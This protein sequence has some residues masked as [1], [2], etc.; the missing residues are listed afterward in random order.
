LHRETHRE[1]R[2]NRRQATGSA[3]AVMQEMTNVSLHMFF[4]RCRFVGV[5]LALA[6]VA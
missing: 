3:G 2:K 6:D 4:G 1:G 5:R